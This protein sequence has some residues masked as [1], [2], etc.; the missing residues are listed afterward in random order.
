[1]LQG[2]RYITPRADRVHKTFDGG[3]AD[4]EEEKFT[5]WSLASTG[6]RRWYQV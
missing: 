4:E 1:M 3:P 2:A 5:F 6:G